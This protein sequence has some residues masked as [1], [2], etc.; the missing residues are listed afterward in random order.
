MFSKIYTYFSGL[1]QRIKRR[2]NNSFFAQKVASF[3]GWQ[4]Q[5]EE[6]S[7]KVR[8]E[9]LDAVEKLLNSGVDVNLAPLSSL[10]PP[11]VHTI[12]RHD[13]P[14]LKLLIKH[15]ADVNIFRR[16]VKDS[17]TQQH[18]YPVLWFE[19]Q[20]PNYQH[21]EED[22]VTYCIEAL[23]Y[24]AWGSGSQYGLE[25]AKLLMS[26]GASNTHYLDGK[27]HGNYLDRPF[28]N[29][30]L[31][32]IFLPSF[33][34]LADNDN[35]M[36]EV[37]LAD[38][39]LSKAINALPYEII[40]KIINDYSSFFQQT[41]MQL[42]DI[43]KHRANTIYQI[44]TERV[45]N[46]SLTDL[47]EQRNYILHSKNLLKTLSDNIFSCIIGPFRKAE[48]LD[49]S[50]KGSDFK[51]EFANVFR[52]IVSDRAI[53]YFQIKGREKISQM[54]NQIAEQNKGK[55]NLTAEDLKLTF[56]VALLLATDNKKQADEALGKLK[57]QLDEGHTAKLSSLAKN[58]KSSSCYFSRCFL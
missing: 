35:I 9:D 48:A 11:L 2:I 13:I 42:C 45:K 20:H 53:P 30:T 33:I 10:L 29:D 41:L 43:D 4:H 26:N 39:S 25:I 15:G 34:A 32:D 1:I 23:P 5:S 49:P 57:N 8:E 18:S 27:C 54:A 28:R 46:L 58:H 21:H 12:L 6:L 22:V 14:M 55:K 40:K 19:S 38:R 44:M 7:R 3:F 47:N 24:P 51:M 36:L 16:P 56:E 50:I 17:S 52:S 37:S 31:A